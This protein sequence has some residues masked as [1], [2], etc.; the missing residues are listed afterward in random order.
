MT[1]RSASPT[2]HILHVIDSLDPAAGGPTEMV[3]SLFAFAPEGYTGE[4][5][6]LDEPGSEFLEA[7]P[8]PVHAL[9]LGGRGIGYSRKLD[10][11]LREN[12][13]RFD[14]VMVHGLWRYVTLAT[15][16]GVRGSKPYVVFPHGMLDPYFKRRF[17]LKHMVK[18][19]Y[20]LCAEY[21]VLRD[22]FRV[23][24]TTEEESRLAKQSFWLHRWNGIVAPLGATRGEQDAE[25]LRA[26]F[27]AQFP[28]L[29]SARFLLFLGRIHPK[30]GCDLL[31]N[32]FIHCAHLAPDLHLVMA[33]PEQQEGGEG[34]RQTV[35]AAGLG[36][37]VHWLGMLQGAVK[38][39]AFHAS[40]AFALPSH[41]ENFGIAVAEALACG[42]PVLL[43][44]KVNIAAE[45][46]GDG[47]GLLEADT[48]DGIDRLL[49][50]WIEMPPELRAKMS[51]Q[52]L[53][54]FAARYDMRRNAARIL[55]LF[56]QA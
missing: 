33:G 34:L 56:E 45:I 2:R 55:Q 54:T 31:I 5:V 20:W 37:R 39:G 9:G 10:H 40:E 48:Q 44:D 18:W 8:F 15:R 30:K 36:D 14:G 1:D 6:S 4:V 38:W 27:H 13:D 47:A 43:S 26:A 53:A 51:E 12:R 7:C 16:N 35:A 25:S 50:R 46:A 24:F 42:L 28:A 21:W 11:W 32:A 19:V 22:A 17:P 3:R 41:Q 49:A 29:R 52:A 23:L